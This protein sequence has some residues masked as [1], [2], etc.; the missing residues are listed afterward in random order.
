MA[1]PCRIADSRVG[2]V[3]NGAGARRWPIRRS[4]RISRPSCEGAFWP[5]PSQR[6]LFCDVLAR[7]IGGFWRY[8]PSILV[9]GSSV[10]TRIRDGVCQLAGPL[11][12]GARRARASYG[13]G[14]YRAFEALVSSL[15][16]AT[17]GYERHRLGW[18]V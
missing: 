9:I 13:G 11:G 10:A 14:N 16:L 8:N 1:R 18:C 4:T 17:T 7:L 2:C 6:Y 12:Y 5:V 15:N 3:R